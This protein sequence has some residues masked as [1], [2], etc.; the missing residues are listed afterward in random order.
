MGDNAGL[1]LAWKCSYLEP[2][3]ACFFRH[4]FV[5]TLPQL[6]HN[7]THHW[8]EYSRL[9]L[10]EEARGRFL[11]PIRNLKFIGFFSFYVDTFPID[12]MLTALRRFHWE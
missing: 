2:L 3:L 1:G 4:G 12:T 7:F 10:S 9:S 5:R 6:I 11:Y 8:F